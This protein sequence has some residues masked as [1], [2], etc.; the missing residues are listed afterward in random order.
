M[1]KTAIKEIQLYL[2]TLSFAEP[3]IHPVTVDGYF[4]HTTT[5][6]VKSFQNINGLPVSGE[7]DFDTWNR[8]I[9]AYEK[10]QKKVLPLNVLPHAD[11][12]VSS[13]SPTDT[14]LI[15]QALLN[16]LADLYVNLLHVTATGTYNDE[17]KAAVMRFQQIHDIPETGLVDRGTWNTLASIYNTHRFETTYR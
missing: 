5:Q 10:L 15:L 16:A 13:Q 9:E 1:D 4:G 8:L 6:A 11:A 3:R 14:I 12:T 7:V 2:R 17:T